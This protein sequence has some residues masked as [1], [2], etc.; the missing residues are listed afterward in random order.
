[1]PPVELERFRAAYL[2]NNAVLNGEG[3][4][5]AFAWVIPDFEW[6]VLGD[7]VPL[8]LRVEAPPVL[9]GRDEVISYP[10]QMADEWEWQPEAD[11]F[12]DPGDGTLVVR[13]QG[14][15]TGR[16]TGLKGVVRFTQVWH[17]DEHGVPIQVRERLDD[18]FLEGTRKP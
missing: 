2:Q 1:M 14:A 18:Y 12:T 9:H 17:F 11:D 16:A 10:R 4:D 6:H 13:V 15:I 3:P 5:G 8:E 7:A